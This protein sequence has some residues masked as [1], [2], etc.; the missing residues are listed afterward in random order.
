MM[1]VTGGWDRRQKDTG[2]VRHSRT[3]NCAREQLPLGSQA[4]L[5]CAGATEGELQPDES[6]QRGRKIERGFALKLDQE[7]LHG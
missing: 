6:G 5:D 3:T 4:E 7:R 2:D 1:P